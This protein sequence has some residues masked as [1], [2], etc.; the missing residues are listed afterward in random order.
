MFVGVNSV[1]FFF[2]CV[3]QGHKITPEMLCSWLSSKRGGAGPAALAA[4]EQQS[5]PRDSEGMMDAWRF[6]IFFFLPRFAQGLIRQMPMWTTEQEAVEGEEP[7][8]GLLGLTRKSFCWEIT[9]ASSS[10]SLGGCGGHRF[11][12]HFPAKKGITQI[13]ALNSWLKN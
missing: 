10:P 8:S 1:Y 5:I 11:F 12:P 4:Q 2:G 9:Q 3:T 6:C 13:V 7:W